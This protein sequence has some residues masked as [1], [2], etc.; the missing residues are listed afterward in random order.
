MSEDTSSSDKQTDGVFKHDAVFKK[1]MEAPSVARDF[2]TGALPP[3][4][5][6]RC[7]LNTLKLEPNTFVDPALRQVASDVVLSMKTTDGSDG[8]IYTLIEHQSSADKYIPVR[9]M[10]YVM[11]LIYRHYRQHNRVPLVIPVLFYHGK[12]TPYPYSLSWPDCMDDPAFAR[13]LYGEAK[14]PRLIDVSLLDDEGLRRYEQMAALMLL[15]Q[16][17]GQN[18]DTRLDFLVQLIEIQKSENQKLLL[19]NYMVKTCDSASPDFLR[20]LAERLPQHEE[21]IMTIA[22]RL[23]QSAHKKGVQLGI[24]QGIQQERQRHLE[25]TYST[26]RRM[27]QRGDSLE[28]IKDMLQLSDEQLQQAL[29]H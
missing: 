4:Q 24:Q 6:S 19:L 22:E 10:Y 15:M 17:R 26:A 14:A 1:M 3:E 9:M 7:N 2:L 29:G 18:V 8:Y 28:D 27:K 13:E 12:E 11:S 21:Q 20:E 16:C 5:L 23:E 25:E